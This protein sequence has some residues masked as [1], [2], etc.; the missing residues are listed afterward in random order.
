M[1]PSPVLGKFLSPFKSTQQPQPVCTWSAHAPQS[2]PLPSP[3]PRN[4]HTLTATATA[5][6]KL[7]LF[8][9][10]VRGYTSSDLYAF[11]A[12]DFSSTLL[13]TSGEVPT[14][15]T[16]HGAALIGTTL[17]ICGGET[18]QNML[19]HDS[20]YL[21]NLGTSDLIMLSPTPVDHSF[22]SRI[23]RVDSCCGRWSWAQRS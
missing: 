6:G 9:G 14:P 19:N 3:F 20:L 1:P 4:G 5:A 17:L 22:A 18:D 12:P 10:R 2:G 23:A 15:R 13:Q 21:L 11:S 8:G 7:F 16:G